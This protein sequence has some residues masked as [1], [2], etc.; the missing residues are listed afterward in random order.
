MV[1]E[2]AAIEEYDDW[3]RRESGIDTPRAI[4]S[5]RLPV[6]NFHADHYVKLVKLS[7]KDVRGSGQFARLGRERLIQPYYQVYTPNS[8][9]KRPDV[10]K[11]RL[12]PLFKQMTKEEINSIKDKPLVVSYPCHSQTVEHAVALT[13]KG[14]KQFRK[15]ESQLG[16]VLST[17][18][19]RASQS[20]KR[21][22][23]KRGFNDIS[24]KI[25]PRKLQRKD[26]E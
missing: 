17:V 7:F 19:A 16:A 12:P 20:F 22:T 23:H 9:A 2:L 11:V 21:V 14:S 4:R 3:V 10:E 24:D 5:Y 25:T 1:K 13:T 8:K 15:P 18:E 6:V 26:S